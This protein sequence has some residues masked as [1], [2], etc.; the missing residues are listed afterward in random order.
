[1]FDNGTPRSA[2]SFVDDALRD[3]PELIVHAGDLPATA[4]ALRD[5][6]AASGRLFD[7]GMVVVKAVHPADGGPPAATRLTVN[8]VVTEAHRLCQPVKIGANHERSAI[9]LP[10]R[11]ARMYLDM[12]GEWRLPPLDGITTARFSRP[13]AQFSLRKA[14]IV[15]PAFGVAKFPASRFPSA[16]IVAVRKQPCSCCG[17]HSA[18]FRLLMR[19]A[20]L[21]RR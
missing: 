21:I 11:V 16:R 7:R 6:F 3:K 9:T 18:L 15:V 17:T 8:S 1:M 2:A 13:T 10:D 19:C 5:L 4:R 20:N 14:M 12:P